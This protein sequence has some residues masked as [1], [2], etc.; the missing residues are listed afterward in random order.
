MRDPDV[1]CG[2]CCKR[3]AVRC[4]T[5]GGRRVHGL[6]EQRVSV[7]VEPVS[8]LWDRVEGKR[9]DGQCGELVLRASAR[10]PTVQRETPSGSSVT[11]V[12]YIDHHTSLHMHADSARSMCLLCK[13]RDI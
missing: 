13:L 1:G 8:T 3:Y 7:V 6:T 10:H 9:A 5:S 11:L 2:C 4:D 12:H